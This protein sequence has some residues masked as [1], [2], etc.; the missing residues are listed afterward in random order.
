MAQTAAQR[1]AAEEKAAQEQAIADAAAPAQEEVDEFAATGDDTG[2]SDAEKLAA[3]EAER[4]EVTEDRDNLLLGIATALGLPEDAEGTIEQLV[5]KVAEVKAAADEAAPAPVVQGPVA[6]AIRLT[7]EEVDGA[8]K[9][10]RKFDALVPLASANPKSVGA[11]V[12]RTVQ[13][14]VGISFDPAPSLEQQ[15]VED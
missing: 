13:Q 10:L 14:I 9:A 11:S 8:G 4:D 6:A 3:A 2:V 5:A 15:P 12:E 1:K 7:V